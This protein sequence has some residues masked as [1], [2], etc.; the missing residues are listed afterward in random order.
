MGVITSMGVT[1]VVYGIYTLG[2]SISDY[3][4]QN[5]QDMVHSFFYKKHVYKTTRP[6]NEISD[7]NTFSKLQ[8][9][10]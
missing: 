4:S 7:D 1:A 6:Q 9:S 10:R 8:V 5:I 3:I 2:I